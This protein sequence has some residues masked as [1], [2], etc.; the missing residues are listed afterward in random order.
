MLAV[1]MS[2]TAARQEAWEEER[3]KKRRAAQEQREAKEQS[4]RDQF[5][6]RAVSKADAAKV[7]ERQLAW[8]AERQVRT[9]LPWGLQSL[10]FISTV[11]LG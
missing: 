1:Q 4:L 3:H 10:C 11:H 8:E 6:G 9:L 7:G 5:A 2:G